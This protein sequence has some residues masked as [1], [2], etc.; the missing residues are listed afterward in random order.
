MCC[1]GDYFFMEKE[2]KVDILK[3][4]KPSHPQPFNPCCCHF[5]RQQDLILYHTIL[6]FNDP[7]KVGC[8]RV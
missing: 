4:Q 8:S 1:H 7:K 5:I 3:V 2:C 6:T